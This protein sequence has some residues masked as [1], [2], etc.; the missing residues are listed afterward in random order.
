MELAPIIERLMLD[1][2]ETY[3]HYRDAGRDATVVEALVR[4]CERLIDG[5]Q[6]RQ[7]DCP[8]CSGVVGA[9]TVR[10]RVTEHDPG[11]PLRRP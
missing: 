2:D 7:R 6:R 5:W 9:R 8:F 1:L 4:R 3:Y 11:C 10:G